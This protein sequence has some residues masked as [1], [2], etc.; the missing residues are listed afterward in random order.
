MAI[1]DWS[2]KYTV[3]DKEMDMQHQRLFVIINELHEAL[4]RCD[5]KE[6]IGRTIAQLFEYTKNHLAAEENLMESCGFP[7]IARHKVTHEKL[8]E[9]L[10]RFDGEFHKGNA[11]APELFVFLVKEWLGK[12][13]VGMDKDYARFISSRRTPRLDFRSA[14]HR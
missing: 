3:H 5:N 1:L 10:N 2:S 9:Q 7:D 13:I 4:L 8:V 14:A 12:H 11:I 6:Q